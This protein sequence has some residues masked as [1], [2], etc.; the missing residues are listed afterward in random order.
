MEFGARDKKHSRGSQLALHVSTGL[1]AVMFTVAG[2]ST[3]VVLLV[4]LDCFH[5]FCQS[6]AGNAPRT[7]AILSSYTHTNANEADDQKNPASL[8]TITLLGGI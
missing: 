1:M 7:R 2:V 6:L 5:S 8:C 4:S 3:T